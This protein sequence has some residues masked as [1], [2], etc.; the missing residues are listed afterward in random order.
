MIALSILTSRE[1]ACLD[2]TLTALDEALEA[3]SG[4]GLV[5]ERE[6]IDL[7]ELSDAVGAELEMREVQDGVYA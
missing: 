7:L 1:L 5:D 3:L 6:G 2:A 4:R